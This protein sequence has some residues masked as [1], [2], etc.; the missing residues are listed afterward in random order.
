MWINK[1]VMN[2]VVSW[3]TEECQPDGLP[4]SDFRRTREHVQPGDVVLVEGRTRVSG[5]IQA[6]TL[7]SWSHSA[8]YVGRLDELP[9]HPQVQKM[10]KKH[11]WSGSQQL[12]AEA[13]LGLGTVLAPLEK[14]DGYHLRI[15]RAS[16]LCPED[17]APIIKFVLDRLGTPYNLR[18]ILDLLRF[19][20]PYGLLPRRWRSSLFEVGHGDFTRTVCSTLIAQA[21]AHV[22]YPVLPTVQRDRHNEGQFVFQRRN[23]KLFTPRDFDYSP[24]FEIIKYPFFGNDVGMYRSMHWLED[25]V[26]EQPIPDPAVTPQAVRGAERSA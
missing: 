11:G 15:C 12:L 16:T 18:Q 13:E 3:L 25:E 2:A 24:Y 10:A 22:R 20:F 9:A 7:S 14:Y 21:F 6:V 4:L 26:A 23:C 17:T 8:L 1:R 5:V 19:F